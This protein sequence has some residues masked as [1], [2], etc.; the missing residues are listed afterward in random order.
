MRNSNS[1]TKFIQKYFNKNLEFR[2]QIYNLLAFMGMVGGVV[3]A[4]IAAMI[5]S[6][7][8]TVGINF[9]L[10]VFSFVM[11]IIADKKKYYEL[12]C[13][14]MIVLIFFIAFPAL[15][16][17]CGGYKSG[18]TSYFI[19]AI[20]FTVFLLDTYKRICVV[21]F[22][23]IL[24]ISC[25]CAAYYIPEM[26]AVLPSAFNYF[27]NVT[28]NFITSGSL[29][30][31]AVMFRAHLLIGNQTEI[32]E[33]NRELKTQNE[34]LMQ[35]DQMKSDF[36]A[37][38]AHEINTPLAVIAASGGDTVDLLNESP[39]NIDEIKENQLVIEKK[40]KLIDNIILDLMD[41]VAIET[42][43]LTLNRQLVN[44]SEFL[45]NTCNAHHKQ[46]DLNNNRIAYAFQTALPQIW[47]DPLRIEQVI[48]NL[49]SNAFRHTTNGIITVKLKQADGGGQIVSV[50]DNGEGM[51]MEMA[52]AVLKQYVSTK[53]DYWRHGIGLY[54]CRRIVSAH[55]GDIWI[56]SEK[57]RGTTVYFT[58]KGELTDDDDE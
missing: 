45:K 33:L 47:L 3:V 11:L 9:M 23:F 35:Y 22:E 2:V 36:L 41:A 39:L 15:F 53:K 4:V 52:R 49:L 24:Y 51:D 20:I 58:L 14:I 50:T 40:V 46:L 13:W 16:F 25:C 38:V 56:E 10:S 32:K 27:F 42:G 18:S 28:L 44:L 37:T 21:I 29:L 54:I 5:K 19:L 31:I 48:V 57:E 34:T 30:L 7:I 12:C 55:G 17:F 43:K 1:K 26:S 8:A 6:S